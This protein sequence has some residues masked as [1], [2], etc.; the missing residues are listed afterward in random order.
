MKE[1]QIDTLAYRVGGLLYMPA[2]QENIVEKIRHGAIPGLSSVAFC[3]EDAIQDNAVM[4]AEQALRRTLSKLAALPAEL[5]PLI[6]IRVRSPEQ[7]RRLHEAN[8]AAHDVI[9]GYI[10]PKFDTGNAKAYL[11]TTRSLNG[12][13]ARRVHI[14]PILESE[15]IADIATRA[16]ELTKLK[17]ML[18][19]M[20]ALVL[21]I[22]VGG[23]DFCRLYGL[24]RSMH[25]TIYD[26]AVVRDIL[27]DILNV[28]A[29]DYVVSGPVWN[30]FGPQTGGEWAQGLAKELEL[31]RL[32]G[33][34]G[35]TAVH[36]A[37]LPLIRQSLAV[38]REDYEDA[39][40]L[41]HWPEGRLGV[42]K[43]THGDQMNEVKCH[44]SWAC[45]IRLLGDIYGIREN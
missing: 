43:S 8:T 7:M 11:E 24:R 15:L 17:N 27:S 25:Q 23:N 19:D 41:L 30:H 38:S 1:E 45:R 29:R 14:M 37:Q 16:A 40:A 4:Q 44:S 3:L 13:S 22:R 21:N 26:I 31:D 35:K 32:N 36:P 20:G 12:E 2:F 10:L 9:T 42:G 18:D 34:T 33:F 39:H 28:F 6:F 5:L